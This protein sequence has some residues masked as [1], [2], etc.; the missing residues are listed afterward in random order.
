M[1]CVHIRTIY[2][3]ALPGKIHQKCNC[4]SSGSDLRSGVVPTFQFAE[5]QPNVMKRVQLFGGQGVIIRLHVY[6]D[7]NDT[8]IHNHRSN[9]ISFCL[10]GKYVPFLHS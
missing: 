4:L 7:P 5:D 9:F 2:V 8:Y 1:Y 10:D 6:D 3:S